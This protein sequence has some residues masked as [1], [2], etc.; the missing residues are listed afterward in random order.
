MK[1]VVGEFIQK[2]SRQSFLVRQFGKE[3][4]AAP[5]HSH[6]EYELTFILEGE[7]KRYVGSN[8]DEFTSGDMVLLGSGIPHCWK[9]INDINSKSQVKAI[10]VHFTLNF[11]GEGFLLSPEMEGI[12]WLL[13]RSLGGIKFNNLSA[14]L[15]EETS[16][17]LHEQNEFNNLIRFLKLLQKLVDVNQFDI[18][19][20]NDV[21]VK[22]NKSEDKRIQKVFAFIVD[23]FRAKITLNEVASIAHMTPQSFCKYFKKVTRKTFTEVVI[24]Y[25][26][27]FASQL[28]THSEQSILTICY[29]SGFG[30]L[31]YFSKT[32]KKKTG[33]TPSNYR[34]TSKVV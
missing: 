10:V 32:F 3:A 7:G 25:R 18:L 5:Y 17:L 30:S 9:L 34:K 20:Q 21:L 28:L 14:S 11:L 2:S 22:S 4:F 27:D 24:D 12:K 23:N 16:A 33:L 6:K 13:E 19:D 31:S 15:K 29:E 1:K 26:V 8:I